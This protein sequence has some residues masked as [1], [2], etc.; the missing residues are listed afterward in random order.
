MALWPAWSGR[1]R[2]WVSVKRRL[3]ATERRGPW[4]L[5]QILII[6]A[7]RID[8]TPPWWRRTGSWPLV[9]ARSLRW[10][11]LV[12]SNVRSR[13]LAD[14]RSGLRKIAPS[15]SE[16]F[17]MP[18]GPKPLCSRAQALTVKRGEQA[19]ARPRPWAHYCPAWLL[20]WDVLCSHLIMDPGDANAPCSGSRIRHT[21][22]RRWH[23]VHPPPWHCPA[24]HGGRTKA[25]ADGKR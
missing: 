17:S 25:V 10:L 14:L 20:A 16:G 11:F 18:W 1:I 5:G 24:D 9:H 4:A 12:V 7:R 13:G 22:D 21:R 6:G 8:Q 19:M 15:R 23:G 3:E 2:A